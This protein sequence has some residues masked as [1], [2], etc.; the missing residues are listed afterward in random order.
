M[1]DIKHLA[2]D[3]MSFEKAIKMA[4]NEA[5]KEAVVTTVSMLAVATPVDEST[6]L[7]NWRATVG[8]P[9]SRKIEAYVLGEKGSTREASIAATIAAAR[10]SVK[11]K[12][13]GQNGFITNN[14]DYMSFLA[15]G[16]SPQ[17]DKA[18][19]IEMVADI[20]EKNWK[21]KYPTSI[22]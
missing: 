20:S 12:K 2:S 3:I 1:K 14:V 5:T 21:F 11:N 15:G 16:G 22:G 8:F 19:W 9:A 6:A 7:S 4:A 13:P 17:Q 10:N 18:G